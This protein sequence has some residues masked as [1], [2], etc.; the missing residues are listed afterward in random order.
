[1]KYYYVVYCF[2]GEYGVLYIDSLPTYPFEKITANNIEQFIQA[3]KEM[4]TSIRP[5]TDFRIISWQEIE[6]D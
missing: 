5:I 1:M 2:R 3:V 6:V 4:A